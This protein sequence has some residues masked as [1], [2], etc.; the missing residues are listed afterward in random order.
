MNKREKK[1][2]KK[3]NTYTQMGLFDSEVHPFL[4][5]SQSKTCQEGLNF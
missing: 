2:R 5:V 1:D 3:E 4:A